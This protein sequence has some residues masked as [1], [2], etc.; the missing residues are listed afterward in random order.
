MEVYDLIF[1]HNIEGY[2][3][4]SKK[5]KS[6]DKVGVFFFVMGLVDVY[7]FYTFATPLKVQFNIPRFVV[8]IVL[9]ILNIIIVVVVMRLF[10]IRENEQMKEFE[11]SKDDSLARYYRI[12]ER[13]NPTLIDGVEISENIDGN[14]F[15]CFQ[16]LYGPNDEEKSIGTYKFFARLFNLLQLNCLDFRTFIAKEIFSQSEECRRFMEFKGNSANPELSK[17]MM[18]VKDDILAFTE[19]HGQLYSTYILIRMTPLQVR[20]VG[21]L[22][23]QIE[24]LANSRNYTGGIKSLDKQNSGNSRNSIRGVKFLDKQN[25]RHFIKEYY[26]VEALDLSSLRNP[27]LSKKVMRMHGHEVFTYEEDLFDFAKKGDEVK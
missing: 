3:S 22:K 14:M 23:T 5:T 15:V 16:I 8:A 1:P 24:E 9:A 4:S 21:S 20:S 25:F 12:R 11:D 18:T 13:E 2:I 6:S 10:V 17:A 26:N 7:L 19:S 27:S